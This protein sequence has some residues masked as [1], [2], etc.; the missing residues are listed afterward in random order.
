MDTAKDSYS[1]AMKK[2]SDGSGNIIKRIENIKRLGAN[3]SKQIPQNLLDRA[4]E[5]DNNLEK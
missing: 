4:G 3:A 2:L 1:E 5:D